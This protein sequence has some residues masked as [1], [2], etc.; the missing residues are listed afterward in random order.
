MFFLTLLIINIFY[1]CLNAQVYDSKSIFV[2]QQVVQ[3]PDQYLLFWN[4]SDTEII[5]KVVV[6]ST[7]WIG[8]GLSP[9][10]GMINSDVVIA[11]KKSD[12][13]FN[14][15]DRTAFAQSE[16]NIDKNQDYTMLFNSQISGITTVIF[17]RNIKIC[18]NDPTEIDFNIE[19][20]TNY[21]IFAWAR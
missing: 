16:P 21:V 2:N 12:G 17:K 20:G 14:F 13:S 11:F 9:N 5:F 7:G 1:N 19:P 15:T 6:K 8:F 4:Y 18:N 10:G 3:G